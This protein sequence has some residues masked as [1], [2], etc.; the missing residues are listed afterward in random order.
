M[1]R[2]VRSTLLL[3]VLFI[4]SCTQDRGAEDVLQAVP[5]NAAMI[6]QINDAS[7]A[8]EHTMKTRLWERLDSTAYLKTSMEEGSDIWD[9]LTAGVAV[10]K[11]GPICV[12][13]HESGANSYDLLITLEKSK[14]IYLDELYMRW[15]QANIDKA[16]EYDG[17]TIVEIQ[18]PKSGVSF[19][20]AEALGLVV[21]SQSDLLVEDALRQLKAKVGLLSDP[22]FQS[23]HGTANRKD[24]VNLYIQYAALGEWAQKRMKAGSFTW[25]DRGAE[26][27]ELDLAFKSDRMI[28]SGLTQV[29][30]SIANYMSLFRGNPA[31]KNQLLDLLPNNTAAVAAI[32]FENFASYQREYETLLRQLNRSDKLLVLK[33]QSQR[34]KAYTSWVDTEFGLALLENP[35]ADWASSSVGLIKFRDKRLAE[36]ALGA[37]A[38]PEVIQYDDFVIRKIEKSAFQIVFGR[39]YKAMNTC[40]Y[41]TYRDYVVIAPDELIIKQF[42]NDNRGG[43]TLNDDPTFASLREELSNKSHVFLYAENPQALSLLQAV[44]RTEFAEGLTSRKEEWNEIAA[45]GWQ[46][47]MED[48]AAHTQLIVRF[49]TKEQVETRL[50]WAITLD[51]VATYAPVIVK[52]HYSKRYEVMTQD[53]A[54][55]VYLIDSK[56]GILWRRAISGQITSDIHQVDRYKNGKLQYLFNTGNKLYML[57]RNGKDVD[58]FPINLPGQASAQV[59]VFD[60]DDNRNYRIFLACG[61]RVLIYGADG[62]PILGWE[63]AQ[64]PQEVIGS[65]ELFQISGRDYLA[66]FLADGQV[67]LRNRRGQERVTLSSKLDL[68][69]PKLYLVKGQTLGDSRLVSLSKSGQFTN[70]FF[71]G[72]VDMT[73]VGISDP[74]AMLVHYKGHQIVLEDQEINVSGPSVNYGYESK[75]ELDRSIV[76]FD[77]GPHFVIGIRSTP[78]RSLWLINASGNARNGFPVTGDVGMTIRDLDLDGNLDLIVA[79]SEGY[80]YNYALD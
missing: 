54:N 8:T 13:W 76:P 26:W 4:V 52:N 66:F 2:F 22:V 62:Q 78:T 50:Q 15:A 25:L 42:L 60:Y 73:D 49:R 59:N 55:V 63:F 17:H 10:D 65:P 77:M 35:G 74:E 36:Q 75:A 47:E 31:R 51:T 16:R 57:D 39:M 40:Y 33:D 6:A 3:L 5:V 37:E 23:L 21:A 24:P 58:G 30:D 11:V 29:S 46:M 53:A 48:K 70:I 67:T 27:T 69:D 12:S 18:L 61:K 9:E 32:S 80:V 41:T 34:Y 7:E 56:G 14:H 64:A 45:L 1:I 72:T 43:R 71:N 19:Y 20:V 38:E 28:A 68:R 79:D 44:T